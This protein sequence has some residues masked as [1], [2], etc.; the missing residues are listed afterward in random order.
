MFRVL[1]RA[2]ASSFANDI[3]TLAA[4]L[5]FYTLLSF[6]PLILLMVWV[7][8]AIGNDTQN[9]LLDQFSTLA[10]KEARAA[11][12]VVIKS[13]TQRPEVGSVAGIFGIF[14]ILIGA[15]SVFSQLQSSL[16]TIWHIEAA[17]TNTFSQW[18]RRR[19]LSVGVLGA[20]GFVLAASLVISALLGLF[21]LHSGLFWDVLNQVTTTAILSILFAALFRYLPD[22]S[23]SWNHALKGGLVTAIL[24]ALGKAAIGFYLVYGNIGSAYGASGSLVVLLVWI[25]YSGAIF[26]FGAELI[27]AWFAPT[28]QNTSA[29]S[30]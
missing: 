11:A 6:A 10:G 9:L 25:Y 24:F 17:P 20:I 19:L 22:A 23:L 29:P 2:V 5:S 15:T 4:A 30:R 8:S 12:Q 18:L 21:F 16:N 27:H 28:D 14:L 26:F 7:S 3:L 1:K 13:A